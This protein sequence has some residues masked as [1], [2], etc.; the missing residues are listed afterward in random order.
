V[1]NEAAEEVTST[2]LE[3]LAINAPVTP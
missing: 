2:L 3:W 1:Q